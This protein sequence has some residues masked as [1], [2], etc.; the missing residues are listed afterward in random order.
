MSGDEIILLKTRDDDPLR[1]A[2]FTGDVCQ[3][4]PYKLLLI[5]RIKDAVF[6]ALFIRRTL[7]KSRLQGV[8]SDF[9]SRYPLFY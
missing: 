5:T 6:Q 3:F 1:Q 2:V 8:S 7:P 4:L 9:G